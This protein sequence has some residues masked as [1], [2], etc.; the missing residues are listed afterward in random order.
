[1]FSYDE[2]LLLEIRIVNL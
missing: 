1:M 2:L